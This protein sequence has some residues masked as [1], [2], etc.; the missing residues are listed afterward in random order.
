MYAISLFQ[1]NSTHVLAVGI[2]AIAGEYRESNDMKIKVKD[3]IEAYSLNHTYGGDKLINID[4]T[5]I[6]SW[7]W[8]QK[9]REDRKS[10]YSHILKK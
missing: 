3:V 1:F 6:P 8:I 4:V 2:K 10:T 5:V 9:I 7:W